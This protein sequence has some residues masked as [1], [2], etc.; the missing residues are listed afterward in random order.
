MSYFKK[1][2]ILKTLRINDDWRKKIDKKKLYQISNVLIAH[3]NAKT[4]GEEKK[5]YY[6]Y[7]DGYYQKNKEKIE[8]AVEDI[9]LHA[10][11]Q[12]HTKEILGHIARKT[13]IKREKL[14]NIDKNL[15]CLKNGI[16]N[17]K[18]KELKP[19]DKKYYFISQIPI[20]YNKK[21]ICPKFLK[22]LSEILPDK[23]IILIQELFGIALFR[24]Y[25]PK[26]AFIF[27]GLKNT[28]K[29]T[30]LTI[31]SAFIGKQNISSVDLQKINS[32][33]FAMA[34]LYKK[35]LNVYDDLSAKDITDTGKFK[36]LTGDGVCPAEYK[37]G[38]QF[39]FTNYA[40]LI[41]ACNKI[42]QVK[43]IDD[44]AYF[45][46]WIVITFKNVIK[47]INPY[48]NEK[49]IKNENEMSGILNWAL[50][51]LDR[52]MTNLKYS[53]DKSDTDI[54]E[55]MVM[56][57]DSIAQFVITQLT[58]QTNQW[59][60]R[61]DMYE[62]YCEYTSQNDLPTE[63]KTM[64]GTKIRKYANYIIDKKREKTNGW[65]NVALISNITEED[66]YIN[67]EEAL[68]EEALAEEALKN[69]TLFTN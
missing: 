5:E 34:G 37:F 33:N 14:N 7:K 1:N 20:N 45:G 32:N 63:T 44:E 58:E 46:R 10:N 3:Y 41:F 49:I 2:S 23:K 54:K 31:L 28:G 30:L 8:E 51:G 66:D 26:K 61:D 19:H 15:I 52:V 43:D 47:I 59:I 56:S 22:F 57:N 25:F 4:T 68:A 40:K 65:L 55:K 53:Y 17:I 29:T 18:T 27:V 69:K 38:N 60:S 35:Y 6:I 13:Y 67:V 50:Q 48:K 16:F 36:I 9:L 39:T 62:K 24:K 11:T 12:H 21:N 64:L 42:P